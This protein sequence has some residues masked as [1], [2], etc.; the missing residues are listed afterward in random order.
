[1]EGHAGAHL[2]VQDDPWGFPHSQIPRSPPGRNQAPQHSFSYRQRQTA[3]L[4]RS[5]R[6][7]MGS[8]N[9]G[10][11]CRSIFRVVPTANGQWKA[12][13]MYT[14]LE[15]LKG[16]PYKVGALRSFELNHEEWLNQRAKDAAF[17][18]T[19]P[20]VLVVGE[21]HGGLDVAVRLKYQDVLRFLSKEIPE[22]AIIGETG[23]RSSAF[24]TQC[25]RDPNYFTV[26]LS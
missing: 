2:D 18:V 21:G 15:Y 23:I 5:P 7:C 4:V 19:D 26:H 22:L 16:M 25:V 12:H 14:N 3:F 24:M 9:L 8:G 13:V 20:K 17:E 6:S 10:D 11:G 1:M